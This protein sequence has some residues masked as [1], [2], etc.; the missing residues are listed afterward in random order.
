METVRARLH[1]AQQRL[2]EQENKD[3]T[4][5]EVIDL[6]LK[7]LPEDITKAFYALG[8]FAPKPAH[9]DRQ[10]AETVTTAPAYTLTV[11]IDRN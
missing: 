4:M 11:L 3:Q 9:F 10:A 6:S 7:T 8:A 2:G 1:L 5:Q